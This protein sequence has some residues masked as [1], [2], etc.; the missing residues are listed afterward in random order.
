MATTYAF[1]K[2]K[3][4]G[5][6]GCIFPF[7]RTISTDSPLDQEFFDYIPAG[8]L[9]CKGQILSAD[10]YPNLATI[11]GVGQSSIYRKEGTTLSE[12][13]QTTQAGGQIQLPDLGS[14]YITASG[15]PGGYINNTTVNPAT[16]ATIYR[17]GVEVSLSSIAQNN[18]VS[19][20]YTGSFAQPE[21]NIPISGSISVRARSSTNTS[22]VYENQMLA[23]G[24]M[25]SI[26]TGQS[27]GSASMYVRDVP[28]RRL[29]CNGANPD[30]PGGGETLP[31][32]LA[33]VSNSL[34]EVGTEAGTEHSHSGLYPAVT[35]GNGTQYGTAS[36]QRTLIPADGLITTVRLN[37]D[38]TFKLDYITPKFILCEYLIKF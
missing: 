17:A 31:S 15:T 9:K 18:L 36:M 38:T 10:Q 1:Q 7:F 34:S 19:F 30:P 20:T 4:G 35:R 26:P 12:R 32:G 22:A 37:T 5:Y 24:H 27:I 6:V 16:N 14:K 33:W 25:T 8:Y 21:T 23:H 2:G 13:N 3:Y 28:T 29:F 11:L